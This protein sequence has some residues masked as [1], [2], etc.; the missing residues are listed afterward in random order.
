[1]AQKEVESK[2]ELMINTLKLNSEK[3]YMMAENIRVAKI[4]EKHINLI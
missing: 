3:M 1:M 4:R 2:V